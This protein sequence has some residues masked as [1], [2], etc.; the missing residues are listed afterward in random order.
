MSKLNKGESKKWRVERCGATSKR[1]FRSDRAGIDF[2]H[3]L[4]DASDLRVYR[5]QFCN[6][7]HLTSQPLTK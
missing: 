3:K 5:C 1:I 6:C 2:I 4:G 7:F